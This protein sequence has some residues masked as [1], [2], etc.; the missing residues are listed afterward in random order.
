M[1][2]LLLLAGLPLLASVAKAATLE[3]APQQIAQWKPD[4][5]KAAARERTPARIPVGIPEPL[6]VDRGINDVPIV[7]LTRPRRGRRR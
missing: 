3:V 1:Q 7:A 6:V 4:C 5:G 2:A